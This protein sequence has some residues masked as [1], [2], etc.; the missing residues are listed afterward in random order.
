MSN[1]FKAQAMRRRDSV[2]QACTKLKASTDAAMLKLSTSIIIT[3]Q[4]HTEIHADFHAALEDIKA[5]EEIYAS[6][7]SRI[8]LGDLAPGLQVLTALLDPMPTARETQA[9]AE[10]CEHLTETE[11]IY[12]GTKLFLK[13]AIKTSTNV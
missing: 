1:P 5:A 10:L 6:L 2:E 4:V 7:P 13:F 8:R 3:N 9:V 12:S 11:T